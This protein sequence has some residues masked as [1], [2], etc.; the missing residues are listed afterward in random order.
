MSNFKPFDL[1]KAKAGHPVVTREGRKARIVCTDFNNSDEFSI[2]SL[3]SRD[4]G[5]EVPNFSYKD[6]KSA[7]SDDHDLLMAPVKKTYHIIIYKDMYQYFSTG[8]FDSLKIVNEI[9]ENL[10]EKF[11]FVKTIS[12]ELEE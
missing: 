10:D 7:I 1:E 4:D 2:L 11:E 8:L 3:I 5:Y 12:F 9:E 6:G